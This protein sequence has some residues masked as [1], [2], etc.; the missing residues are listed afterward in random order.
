MRNLII[1]IRSFWRYLRIIRFGSHTPL[2][3][4]WND[5]GQLIP[6]DD[7]EYRSLVRS[8]IR[9]GLYEYYLHQSMHWKMFSSTESI[10]APAVHE[11]LH[12]LEFD[13]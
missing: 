7:K 6:V 12:Q 10:T 2:M 11:E 13:F 5:K 3:D 9:I 8:Y 4:I 1:H